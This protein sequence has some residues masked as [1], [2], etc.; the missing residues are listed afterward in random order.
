MK[1]L[2]TLNVDVSSIPGNRLRIH[3]GADGEKYYELD[4]EIKVTFCS[5]HTD[6]S[7]WRATKRY[8]SVQAEYA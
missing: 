6:Y 4:C 2:V 3:V 1:H 8:G 7:L 5:A